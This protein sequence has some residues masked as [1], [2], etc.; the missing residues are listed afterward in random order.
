M[1]NK[2]I[3]D[4]MK[5]HADQEGSGYSNWYC[6]IAANPGRR[7]FNDHNVPAGENKAWW[8]TRNASNEQDARDTESY[9]MREKFDGGGGGGDNTTI[10]VYAYKKISGVTRERT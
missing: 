3:V 6:G 9:L 2:E 7:L 8:I 5:S 10:H 1:T 4:D